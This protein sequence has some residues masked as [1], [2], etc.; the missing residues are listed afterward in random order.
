MTV[1]IEREHTGVPEGRPD[2]ASSE[3]L[4]PPSPSP[5][6]GPIAQPAAP[7]EPIAQPM[8]PSEPAAQPAA[9]PSQAAIQVPAEPAAAPSRRR[10]L[11]SRRVLLPAAAVILLIVAAVGG[12]AYRESI[13]YVSTDNAQ[14]TGQP[15]QVGAMNAGRVDAVMPMI[16]DSVHK[17][18]VLAQVALPSQIGMGQNG[19]PKLG[20]LGAGDTHVDV[21]SPVDGVVI[22]LPVGVGSV[23]S[24][25]QAIVTVVDPSQLWVNANIEET[26][27]ARVKPGQP[28]SVHVDALGTDVPG[29]VAAVTPA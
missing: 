10:R 20:F 11:S 12:N 4:A 16:G 28:V 15:I 23:V 17:G 7:T 25:G 8:A 29:K 6:P 14:L 13:M 24:Q 3:P 5:R 26:N 2:D 1:Q 27:I 22:A 19:Q 18:D 9:A 21:Q